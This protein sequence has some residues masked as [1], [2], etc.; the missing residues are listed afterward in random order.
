MRVSTCRR[1][2]ESRGSFA[3]SE[4]D[5]CRDL[6][7]RLATADNRIVLF[8]GS[9]TISSANGVTPSCSRSEE[10]PRSRSDKVPGPDIGGGNPGIDSPLALSGSIGAGHAP[11]SNHR[12]AHRPPSVRQVTAAEGSGWYNRRTLSCA[13]QEGK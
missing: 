7:P 10:M 8:L 4:A 1:H 12:E 2:T 5:F 3:A 9:V 11:L 13:R 6:A